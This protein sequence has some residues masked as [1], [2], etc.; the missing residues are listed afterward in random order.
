M[1]KP[2]FCESLFSFLKLKTCLSISSPPKHPQDHPK[3]QS[4][5]WKCM[6]YIIG[7]ETFEKIASSGLIANFTVY[8]VSHFQMKQVDAANL[9]QVFFGTTNFAPLVGAFVAD[10]Y[11]GRFRTLAYASI[12]SFL[13]Y[14][15]LKWIFGMV[16]LTLTA[17]VPELKPPSC[18]EEAKRLGQCL[19]PSKAQT[20]VLYLSL[21]L[22]VVG[23]GGI[24]PCSLPFGVDQFDPNTKKDQEGLNS[25][26]NWYY[27]TSTAALVIGLT[28]LVYI[29]DSISWAIGF[30]I[31]TG[32]MLFSIIFFF[33]GVGLYVYVPPQGSI[34]SGIVQVFVASFKK[35]SLKLP[36]P[37]DLKLQEAL[38]YNPPIKNDRVIK[39]P[40][41][42]QFSFLNKAAIKSEDDEIKVEDNSPRNPWNLCSIQQIEEVKCLIRIIPIWFSGIICFLAMAQQWTFTVLQSLTMDRHL[43]PHFQIPAGTIASISLLSLTIFMP[44]YDQIFVPLARNITKI[45]NGITLLQRQGLGQV[46]SIMA[47][48]VAGLVEKKRRASALFYGGINGSS[49]LT[50]MWLAPQLILMGIAEAFNAVGQIEFYNRQFPE[51]MQTLAGSLFFCSLAGASYLSSF[52]VTIV[53]KTTSGNQVGTSWLEDNLNVGRLD[54]FYYVIALMGA[55][56]LI[57]FMVCAHFYRYK[58]IQLVEVDV[59]EGKEIIP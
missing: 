35:R 9:T 47:M 11:L 5:G 24:R 27:C 44:I 57:Y 50:A 37:H 39:L 6:P 46:F 3:N 15:S 29:Q 38:L 36:S 10:A 21:A 8:L 1:K 25:F 18:T 42:S 56:N 30:G 20:G 23:A 4:N 26:F 32:L 55:M 17:L 45:D 49:P 28:V 41:S 31:P 51:H 53:K 59:S 7:N 12:T 34:L 48:V 33:L 2:S 58:G 19:G 22:L 43:G 16:A 40:W 52:L 54:L 13:M 14:F